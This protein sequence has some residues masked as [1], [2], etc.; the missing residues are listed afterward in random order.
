MKSQKKNF[1]KNNGV[2]C[3]LCNIE[4]T[5]NLGTWLPNR[6]NFSAYQSVR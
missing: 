4:P 1:R 6:L 2:R 5:G 3:I